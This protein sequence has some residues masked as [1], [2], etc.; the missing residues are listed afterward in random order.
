MLHTLQ[1]IYKLFI[2][3]RL[4]LQNAWYQYKFIFKKIKKDAKN[5]WLFNKTLR[6]FLLVMAV[7]ILDQKLL[8]LKKKLLYKI[9]N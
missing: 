3:R 5:T 6:I 7:L 9:K 8:L 1:K 2:G 4:P